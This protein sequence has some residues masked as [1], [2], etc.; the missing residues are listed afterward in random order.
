M[1]FDNLEETAKVIFKLNNAA[2][3]RSGY[4]D[5]EMVASHMQGF[6]Y[7]LEREGHTSGSTFGYQLT[8]FKSSALPF[9]MLKS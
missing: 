7:Q 5:V 3:N 4:T 1:K 8:L 2:L 9:R 6:A